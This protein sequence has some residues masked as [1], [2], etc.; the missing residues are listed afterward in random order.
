MIVSPSLI[1][2]FILLPWVKLQRT[3]IVIEFEFDFIYLPWIQ[4]ALQPLD[5][6][7]DVTSY[8]TL[9]HIMLPV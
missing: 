8:Y 6:E 5:I 7:Q 1:S 4:N 2:L 3:L 9:L